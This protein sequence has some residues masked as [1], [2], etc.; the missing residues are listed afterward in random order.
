MTGNAIEPLFE[1][2]TTGLTPI[3]IVVAALFWWRIWG[4]IGLVMSTPLTVILVALGRHFEALKPF[5]ILLGNSPA[6]SDPEALYRSMLARNLTEATAQAKSFMATRTLSEYCDAVARP[7]LIFAQKD[8]QRGALEGGALLVFQT[9]FS[10]L[11]DEI[12]RK[13]WAL[14]SE[15]TD[16]FSP[17]SNYP[18]P[19]GDRPLGGGRT[20]RLARR[21]RR[22]RRSGGRGDRHA[23]ADPWPARCDGPEARPLRGCVRMRLLS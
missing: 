13:R 7:A 2:R 5:D 17:R 11:F 14:E 9:T 8:L 22:S 23:R 20:A 1:G 10:K 15:G 6:L 12:A 21:A 4:S 18:Q 3:A 19:R 16:G